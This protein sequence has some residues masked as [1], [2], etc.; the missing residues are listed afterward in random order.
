MTKEETGKTVGIV[1]ATGLV[2]KTIASVL[3]ERNFP[4]GELVPIAT[5]ASSGAFVQ[6]FGE[7]WKIRQLEDADFACVE[8][9]FF[10]A[11]RAVSL[12]NV[13]AALE[14]GCRVVDNTTAY[15]MKE[16]IPLV[17]PEVNGDLVDSRVSLV[18]SPNCTAIIL[19]M[20][21]APIHKAAGIKRVVVTSFQSVSGTGREALAELDSQTEADVKGEECLLRVYP[22]Q[23]AY[24]CLPQI[25]EISVRGYSEEEEKIAEETRKILSS[26]GMMVVP[27][28]ARVP[29]RVGHSIAVSVELQRDLAV[30]EA[31]EIW[32]HSNGV[33][34]DSGLPTAL[35]VAGSDTVVVGRVRRDE[36]VPYGIVFWVVGDN[37]RKGAATNSV[38]IAELML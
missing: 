19:T 11:G 4:V 29:V 9:C 1:G 16:G 7:N 20:A 12:K 21:L 13:P 2:G 14:R 32:R 5:E 10:T 6:A 28:A 31:L 3:E 24:N 33:E 27:T 22:K 34:T 37:L 26:P 36:T 18:S 23:I 38:Q 35:D 8:L 30:E 17:V 15:R 25:G